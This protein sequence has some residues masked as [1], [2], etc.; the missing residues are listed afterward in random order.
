MTLINFFEKNKIKKILV[1][2]I[3]VFINLALKFYGGVINLFLILG[4]ILIEK[5]RLKEKFFSYIFIA[6][7]A[8]ISVLIFYQPFSANKTG[9]PLIFSPFAMV[10]NLIEER[11]L[12]YLP[13]LVNARYFLYESGFG[14]RLLMIEFFSS[15]LFLFFN[16][17]VRFFG[18]LYFLIDFFYKKINRLNLVI[19][20]TIV[21]SCLL[22]I[23]FIQKGMWWNTIQFTYYG[24]FLANIFTALF[25]IKLLSLKNIKLLPLVIFLILINIPENIDILKGFNP[26]KKTSFINEKELEALN[27]LKKRD[28]GII[29]TPILSDKMNSIHKESAYVSAF[30]AK[31]TYF[32][33]LH[34]LNITGVDWR[35]REKEIADIEKINLE[36]LPV[37]YFYLLKKDKNYSIL[38]QKINLMKNYK[39]IFDNQEVLIFEK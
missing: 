7:F 1:Y 15:F 31:P 12:F 3:I 18:L 38:I 19:F 35:S 6:S 21:F 17:G 8:T 28:D 9:L 30:A 4:L 32:N 13:D 39:K 26:L 22:T 2:S 24:L 25:L 11:D 5:D 34:V 29:F 16:F 23:S 14:P 33:D 10:H 27:F 36:K 20:L 37:R